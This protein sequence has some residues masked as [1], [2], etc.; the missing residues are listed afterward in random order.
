MNTSN[1]FGLLILH[2]VLHVCVRKQVH[3]ELIWKMNFLSREGRP[4]PQERS[5]ADLTCEE[6]LDSATLEMSTRE[7]TG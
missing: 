5:L 7:T 3:R 4:A 1:C 2:L 6:V